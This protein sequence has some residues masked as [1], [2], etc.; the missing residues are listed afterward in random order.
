MDGGGAVTA[1]GC[2]RGR[3]R[4][5]LVENMRH[6]KKVVKQKGDLG[7]NHRLVLRV[8][9]G[10]D[11][12]SAAG[13]GRRL[14]IPVYSLAVFTHRRNLDYGALGMGFSTVYPGLEDAVT[15]MKPSYTRESLE[16]SGT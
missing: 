13:K 9:P 5:I 12:S 15:L 10:C 2:V 14:R 16:M 1:Q 11:F 3:F 6:D 7:E 8:L 4:K